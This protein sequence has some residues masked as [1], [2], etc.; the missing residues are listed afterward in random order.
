MTPVSGARAAAEVQQETGSTNYNLISC[1]R[2]GNDGL[3]CGGH[4][5]AAV[6]QIPQWPIHST[7]GGSTRTPQALLFDL[8]R[9]WSAR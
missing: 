5:Q 6:L 7:T 9:E 2:F 8:R 4:H 1:G 3:M